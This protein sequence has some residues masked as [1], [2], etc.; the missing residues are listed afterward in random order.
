MAE[1][2]KSSRRAINTVLRLD[3]DKCLR[4]MSFL[5]SACTSICSSKL[6]LFCFRSQGHV[7]VHYTKEPGKDCPTLSYCPAEGGQ[8]KWSYLS[9]MSCLAIKQYDKCFKEWQWYMLLFR[10]SRIRQTQD[11][12]QE[13]ETSQIM[14]LMMC[15][16]FSLSGTEEDGLH[17]LDPSA[18]VL[19]DVIL[20]LSQ[21]HKL[22]FLLGQSFHHPC[23]VTLQTVLV[24]KQLRWEE[25]KILSDGHRRKL[26]LSPSMTWPLLT[27]NTGDSALPQQLATMLSRRWLVV[28]KE[29]W[30]Q[31]RQDLTS[32]MKL[33]PRRGKFAFV[34]LTFLP[35]L[36]VSLT[37]PGF[38]SNSIH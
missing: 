8:I 19:A 12:V 10:K 35:S 15:L 36:N 2:P 23:T 31:T 11:V 20:V 28:W 26:G 30:K 34:S 13:W 33:A 22:I 4:Y 3:N 32:A 7:T 14:R 17:V 18:E 38:I 29:G 21:F 27:S 1:K 37:S 9:Q 24:K 16:L 25:R 5:I 6:K